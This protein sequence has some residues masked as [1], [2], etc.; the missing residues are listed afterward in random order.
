MKRFGTFEGVFTPTI[1]S[2]LGVIM[3]LR[4]G[5]VIGNVGLLP[6]IVIIVIIANANRYD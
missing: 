6:T 3:F 2:I 1:L 5:W 4:L